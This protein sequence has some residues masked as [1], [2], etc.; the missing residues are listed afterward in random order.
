MT[1]T[2]KANDLQ[3]LKDSK[4]ET[5]DTTSGIE[6]RKRLKKFERLPAGKEASYIS[7]SHILRFKELN[8]KNKVIVCILILYRIL[9]NNGS[10]KYVRRN[11]MA[12]WLNKKL[13]K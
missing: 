6:Q 7:Y 12:S 2:H 3:N 11:V 9:L 13:Y 1:E 10:I 8:E 4:E 5:T